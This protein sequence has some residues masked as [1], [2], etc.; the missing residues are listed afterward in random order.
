MT[1]KHQIDSGI[2]RA[3]DIRGV[4]GENLSEQDA[5]LIGRAFVTKLSAIFPDKRLRICVGYDGRD[6]SPILEESLVKGLVE[7]GADVIRVGLGPSPMLYFAVKHLTAD[8]GIMVTGS[9]NPPEY[10]GFKML[11]SKETFYGEEIEHL[12]RVANLGHFVEGDGTPMNDPSI[13]DKYI[14]ELAKGYQSIEGSKE[15]KVAWDPGN[16]AAGEVVK[17]LCKKLPGEHI[18]IN[19]K[20]DSTFPNHHPD[21]TVAENLEQLIGVVKDKK[22]DFGVAFDGDGDRVGAVDGRGRIIWGDQLMVFFAKD[23]LVAHPGATI[24]ADVK[25]SQVLFDE[26]KRME[27]KPVMWKTGHSLIKAKI[28]EEGAKLAG[29]MSGHIFF[30]DRY[31]GFDDG[32]YAAVRLLNLAAHSDVTVSKMVDELPTTHNT[33]EIRIECDDDRKFAVVEEIRSRLQEQKA[34]VNGIDG[35]RVNTED[36]WWLIRASN[37]QPALVL[38]C[39]ASNKKGLEK[40]KKSVDGYLKECGVAA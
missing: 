24:I 40:L 3:Y 22:C 26:V 17:K 31:Y 33:P 5:Y 12:A 19:E 38:R 39:E 28:A 27:G 2:I 34:D 1:E 4:V 8:G 20:I 16:G 7:S 21:P 37:T 35:V 23:V 18:L 13:E 36:G 6:S 15:L 30:A 10:N 9:H 25:A 11:T 29:E 32:I 14:E